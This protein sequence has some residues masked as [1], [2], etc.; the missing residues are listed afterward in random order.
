MMARI[1]GLNHYQWKGSSI[2]TRWEGAS[3]PELRPIY[4]I[5]VARSDPIL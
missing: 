2:V 3:V 4:K 1:L 5:W